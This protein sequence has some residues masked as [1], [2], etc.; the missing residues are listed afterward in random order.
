M[1]DVIVTI[2]DNGPI[3]ILGPVTLLDYLAVAPEMPEAEAAE[4]RRQGIEVI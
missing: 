1:A 2:I 3:K 4:F